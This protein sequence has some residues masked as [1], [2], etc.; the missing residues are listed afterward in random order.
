MKKIIASLLAVAVVFLSG[1]QFSQ[2]H[3]EGLT[4]K[5]SK[6]TGEAKV[7]RA[8]QQEE[9]AAKEGMELNPGDIVKTGKESFV[10]TTFLPDT[11][12][13]L[14][15]ESQLRITKFELNPETS[16]LTG[17]IDILSGHISKTAMN[18]LPAGSVFDVVLS[19]YVPP[20]AEGYSA[21]GQLPGIS[22]PLCDTSAGEAA[23]E[24]VISNV[25]GIVEIFRVGSVKST[26]ASN[27]M[28]LNVG[29]ML[30]T[31]K[32]S[33]SSISFLP[34]TYVKMGD[35]SEAKIIRNGVDQNCML[36]T[37]VDVLSGH[38]S[39]ISSGN[40]PPGSKFEVVLVDYIPLQA[41]GYT[42]ETTP[43][44]TPV[45]FQSASDS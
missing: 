20:A 35:N 10:T 38:C 37:R 23:S 9:I 21:P 11:Y 43:V 33:F 45:N 12:I 42:P 14:A 44:L 7:I 19:D 15:S 27:G 26:Q 28:K 17:R 3:A 40:L 1:T 6:I 16:N 34:G 29:D 32:D 30:K 8:G 13:E 5:I 2:A 18:D 41:E 22:A 25:S 4:A 24:A 39:E 36:D 31:G